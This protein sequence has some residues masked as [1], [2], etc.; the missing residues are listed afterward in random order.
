M[1]LVAFWRETYSHDRERCATVFQIGRWMSE[2]AAWLEQLGPAKY[3]AAFTENEVELSDLPHLTEDD[4]EE[5]GLPVGPRRRV[6][7]AARG[8]GT[9]EA[10]GEDTGGAAPATETVPSPPDG[11]TRSHA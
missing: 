8:L 10:C 2:V 7:K 6:M 3:C 4:L 1:L 9:P 5:I 11:M